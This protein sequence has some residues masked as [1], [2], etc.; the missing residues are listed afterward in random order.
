[1][2]HD[3]HSSPQHDVDLLDDVYAYL[4]PRAAA[5]Q[6]ADRGYAV[7]PC[8]RETKA[9]LTKHGFKD[10]TT[11]H[12]VIDQMWDAQPRANVGA[13]VPDG[14]IVI[15]VD[16]DAGG[17]ET[18]V[19]L[20]SK[21]GPLPPSRL[22]VTGGDDGTGV[23][24][25][26]FY[27]VTVP[28][29]DI[30]QKAHALGQGVDLRVGG[31]GYVVVYGLHQSGRC[32][33][34][35]TPDWPDGPEG[36]QV[37]EVA[38][39]PH[40]W[41]D[42]LPIRKYGEQPKAAP[43]QDFAPYTGNRGYVESCVRDD[44]DLLAGATEGGRNETL[45]AVACNLFEWAKGN[46]VDAK[47]AH[48]TLERL[49]LDI[50][51]QP[52]KVRSTLRSA[53][54]RVGPRNPPPPREIAAAAQIDAPEGVPQ[55]KQDA[56][57]PIGAETDPVDR[58]R[59]QLK[60]AYQLAKRVNGWLL[61]VHG[62][63]WHYW[64]K[65]RWVEDDKGR[66]KQAVYQM[67]YEQWSDAWGDK[68]LESELKRCSTSSG[69]AGILELAAAL[70]EFACTVDEL[71]ADPFLLNVA[72][73]TLDLHTLQLRPHAPGDRCTKVCRGAYYPETSAATWHQFLERVLPDA[74][75]RGFM[76]RLA[77]L[78]LLGEV[79]EHLLPI[80][81]GTGRNGKSVCAET[82]MFAL[83]DYAAAADPELFTPRDGAHTTGVTDLRGQRLVTVQETNRERSLNEALM[84]RLTGGDRITARRMRQN[85]I[86]FTPSH[87]AIM[88]TNHLPKV[89]G[90]D[91]ATWARLRVVPF[92]VVIPPHE[93]DPNLGSRLQLE[94]DG[95]LA[96]AVEGLR[97]YLDRGLA[98]PAKVK[99]RTDAYHRDMD[100]VARFI[101]ECCNT[102]PAQ[103]ATTDELHQE[104]VRWQQQDGCDPMGRK[105]FGLALDG[106]GYPAKRTRIGALRQGIGIRPPDTEFDPAG[107]EQHEQP[108]RDVCDVSSG[109]PLTRTQMG[110]HTD[111]TS[112][113]SPGLKITGPGR[114]DECSF[115]VPTQGHRDDCSKRGG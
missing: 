77:G 14:Q 67:L 113:T 76:Q 95:V 103:R 17:F 91:P 79:K 18:V 94:A 69:I 2:A 7:F 59:G 15:D 64:D 68:A 106:K 97:D 44:L 32:Y 34:N 26:T 111:H 73:G 85:N 71:D 115:H 90:D 61:H 49:A 47:W 55:V 38:Q 57:P 52:D 56:R 81:T 3:K 109:S 21:H 86:T 54:N 98:E 9:P 78:A 99:V 62:L 48:D 45:I 65:T 50:G 23:N 75:V 12:A 39:L 58:H 92:D 83:G 101:T 63:G 102:G 80:L 82:L 72:N 36:E 51:E 28:C 13:A 88:I 4:N 11:D 43:S 96:W 19:A 114:C 5:H 100:A 10:A 104:W 84:K 6:W 105:A 110:V 29:A 27:K 25:H 30:K 60:F 35:M 74:E 70:P 8:D 66:A 37:V 87:L 89:S 33:I 108:K 42:A 40:Q 46:H 24:T 107:A 41:Y 53:W 93:Q 31:R 22:H 112:Q 1:M 20:L 16:A